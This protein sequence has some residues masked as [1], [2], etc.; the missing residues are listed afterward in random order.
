MLMWVLAITAH[1]GSVQN[2]GFCVITGALTDPDLFPTCLDYVAD[3]GENNDLTVSLEDDPVTGDWQVRFED[4]W[5]VVAGVG[6]L[7]VNPN[8]AVCPV[9]GDG[10]I[11]EILLEDENDDLDVYDLA[12][13]APAVQ[14]LSAY[15]DTGI[16]T[17]ISA[18][19]F[20]T[21]MY[22]GADSD[23]LVAGTADATLH[24][25]PGNDIL[26]G[27]SGDDTLW[28]GLGNDRL[29]ARLGDDTLTGGPGFDIL[30]A[31]AGADTI[32]AADGWMDTIWC[33]FDFDVDTVNADGWDNQFGC[34]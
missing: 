7:Q 19:A 3:E 21:V 14:K 1:A 8:E 24:G 2:G 30:R 27:G 25:G 23:L 15:G 29:E 33:G 4:A 9:G 12:T 26:Y 32:D 13:A 5:P 31:G 34:P 20:E 22:G 10:T 11:V 6:C 28:G 17:M 16:D 18:G